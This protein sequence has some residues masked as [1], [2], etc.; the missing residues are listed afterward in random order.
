[1]PDAERQR[2]FDTPMHRVAVTDFPLPPGLITTAVESGP[3]SLLRVWPAD[4]DD[5]APPSPPSDDRVPYRSRTFSL[6]NTGNRTLDRPKK[7]W[8]VN[9]GAGT[10]DEHVAGMTRLSLKS[11]INDPSQMRESLCWHLFAAAGVH[12][13]RHTF[14]TLSINGRYRGLYAVVEDVDRRYLKDRFGSNDRGNLYKAACG[15][16]GCATLERRVG[17]DG[18]D[19]GQQYRRRAQDDRRFE[20]TY[21]LRTNEDDPKANSYDDLAELIRAVQGV[22]LPNGAG[23]AADAYRENLER[24]LDVHAFLRWAAVNVLVSGWDNYFATPS[25]YFLYNG[26]RVGAEHDFMTDPYFVFLPWDY[27]NTFGID[28]FGTKWQYTPLTDWPANTEAYNRFNGRGKRSKIPLVTNLMANR[29][30]LGYYLDRVEDLL[31]TVFSPAVI[32]QRTTAPGA[33]WDRITPDVYWESDSPNGVP[34]SGRQFSN[35]EVYRTAF[36]QNELR[37]P[38]AMIEGIQHYT[39][40]RYDRARAELATLRR[41]V[42]RGPSTTFPRTPDPLPSR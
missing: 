24:V 38:D 37:R 35:D 31:D 9:V 15:T 36:G 12:A 39:L 33:L 28:Y 1:M 7:S 19:S 6:V 20:P 26:G 25:N 11:M 2:F 8:R 40:M 29:D 23:F 27:D 21:D 3:E 4:S 41:Q 16:R 22:G 34:F 14:A 30:Y 18:D 42:P 13:S 5:S 17:S 32:G 10:D